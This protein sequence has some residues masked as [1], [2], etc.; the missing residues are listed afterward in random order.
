MVMVFQWFL[1]IFSVVSSAILQWF[2]VSSGFE[3]VSSFF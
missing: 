1:M 2:V 3:M